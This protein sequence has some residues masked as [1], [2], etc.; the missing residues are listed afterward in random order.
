MKKLSRILC[1]LLGCSC[2]LNFMPEVSNVKITAMDGKIKQDVRDKLGIYGCLH[3]RVLEDMEHST[4]FHLAH[5]VND[6]KSHFYDITPEDKN[7][8]EEKVCKLRATECKNSTESVLSRLNLSKEFNNKLDEVLDKIKSDNDPTYE[9]FKFLKSRCNE[10][11]QQDKWDLRAIVEDMNAII[12]IIYWPAYKEK[13][14]TLEAKYAEQLKELRE[15][16]IDKRYE[17]AGKLIRKDEFHE[18]VDKVVEFLRNYGDLIPK[19]KNSELIRYM[20]NIDNLI[21]GNNKFEETK[22]EEARKLSEEWNNKTKEILKKL[23][24]EGKINECCSE[25]IKFL[26]EFDDLIDPNDKKILNKYIDEITE[27]MYSNKVGRLE[28]LKKG[29]KYKCGELKRRFSQAL[30]KLSKSKLSNKTGTI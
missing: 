4:D 26:R 28:L 27:A 29:L 19:D 20:L 16:L 11:S 25:G 6:L 21:F 10:I 2:A 17:I 30:S 5:R 12:R 18:C 22:F 14:E 1:K 15:E 9:I 23:V 3:L 13:D 7:F 24:Y 8:L